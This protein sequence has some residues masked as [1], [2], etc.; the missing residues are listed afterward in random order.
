[1]VFPFLPARLI[2]NCP[3][4]EK[5]EKPSG[6]KSSRLIQIGLVTPSL[7][8]T[9]PNCQPIRRKRESPI[10]VPKTQ[11]AFHQLER[12]TPFITMHARNPDCARVGIN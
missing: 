10:R 1:M 2:L 9:P 8:K 3:V 7:A 6:G 12:G 11:S 5:G 4:P